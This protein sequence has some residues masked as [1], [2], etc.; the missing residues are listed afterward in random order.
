MATLK[1]IL[2]GSLLFL[3]A[4]TGTFSIFGSYY[5]NMGVANPLETSSFNATGANNYVTNW[6][7]E[8]SRVLGNAQ[9]IPF[10]G[11]TFTLLTGAFQAITFLV[12]L[13]AN[14]LMPILNSITG[15]L[16]LPFWFSAFL[17]AAV[18]IIFII[19]MLKAMGVG[20]V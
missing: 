9:A 17:F 1:Q 6:A 19:A 15:A 16:L 7:N 2:L 5:S 14:V 10:I 8:T 18:L 12:G 20:G 11:G 4:I 13:P 3:A